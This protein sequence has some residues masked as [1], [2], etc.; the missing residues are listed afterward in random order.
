MMSSEDLETLE[1]SLHI[2]SRAKKTTMNAHDHDPSYSTAFKI[3]ILGALWKTFFFNPL[4]Y[5]IDIW[6]LKL[7]HTKQKHHKAI[8]Q[9][10]PSSSKTEKCAEVSGVLTSNFF[11][12]MKPSRL[13]TA[14]SLK[15]SLCDGMEVCQCSWVI[16]T[17][18]K[19]PLLLKGMKR[20]QRM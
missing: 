15:A 18:V 2:R 12:E 16:C 10:V 1:K 11:P 9:Q 7:Y 3:S 20:F 8:Y 13:F 19:T 5:S 14:Q 4:H 17:S 6:P